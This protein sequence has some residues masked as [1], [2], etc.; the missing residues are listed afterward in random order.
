MRKFLA[1]TIFATS[2]LALGTSGQL[3][4]AH[5]Q[6]DVRYGGTIRSIIVEGNRRIEARTVQSYLLV[7][8]GDAFDPDRID[9]S[10]KTLFATNLFADVSIDRREDD[11]VVRVVE[12]PI[13]NRVIF[14]G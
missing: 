5:A 9:L 2:V 10:L 7:E 13:I 6:E 4:T 14:E 1:A 8:P 12:N 11:L 3:T